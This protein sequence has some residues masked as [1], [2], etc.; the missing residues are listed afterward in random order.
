VHSHKDLSSS[1][2]LKLATSAHNNS[3]AAF[4]D[5]SNLWISPTAGKHYLLTA[6]TAAARRGHGSEPIILALVTT[7]DIMA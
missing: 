5:G 3:W 6:S 4:N 2:L 7:L 1:F